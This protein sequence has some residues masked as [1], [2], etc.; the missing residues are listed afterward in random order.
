MAG[1]KMWKK[2]DGSTIDAAMPSEL[3]LCK[4]SPR[5]EYQDGRSEKKHG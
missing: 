3:R 5:E 2:D 1:C 4:C